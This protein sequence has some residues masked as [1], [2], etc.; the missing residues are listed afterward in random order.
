[1]NNTTADSISSNNISEVLGKQAKKIQQ[2]I[3]DSI[4]S[5]SV[6]AFYHVIILLYNQTA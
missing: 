5:W 1:M 2:Q 4:D 6:D 3:Y